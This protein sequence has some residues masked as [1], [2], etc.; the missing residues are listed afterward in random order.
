[1]GESKLKLSWSEIIGSRD[2]RTKNCGCDRQA[3][4]IFSDSSLEDIKFPRICKKYLKKVLLMSDVVRSSNVPANNANV[5]DGPSS[6]NIAEKP[7]VSSNTDK[8]TGTTSSNFTVPVLDQLNKSLI[9]KIEIDLCSRDLTDLHS[10]LNFLVSR[11]LG[12]GSSIVRDLCP[13]SFQRA[14][15]K[16]FPTFVPYLSSLLR[17]IT[18]SGA[19][20][21]KSPPPLY[22]SKNIDVD[23]TRR[24]SRPLNRALSLLQLVRVFEWQLRWFFASR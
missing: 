19:Q 12:H 3:H 22:C 20:N 1:M 21:K 17:G 2:W 23:L 10:R 24:S 4:C 8:S 6:Q 13:P 15:V 11:G 9:D 5:M 18:K 16:S 7:M 14:V